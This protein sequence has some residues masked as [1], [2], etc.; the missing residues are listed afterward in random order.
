MDISQDLQQARN[1]ISDWVLVTASAMSIPACITSLMR[2]RVIGWYWEMNLHA[3]ATIG[4]LCMVVFRHHIS[5]AIRTGFLVG[6]GFV[7]GIAGIFQFGM[8]SSSMPLLLITPPMAGILFGYRVGIALSVLAVV[9]VSGS[10]YG[11]INQKLA[12][13]FDLAA[14]FTLA[15]SWINF[16]LTMSL[17]LAVSVAANIM[18]EKQFLQ[19]LERAHQK[20]REL[21]LM[22]DER[23]VA[24]LKARTEAERLARTDELTGLPNRRAFMEK[25]RLMDAQARRNETPYCILMMDVDHFKKIN[26][27]WGHNGGD[28]VLRNLG[29]VL[30]GRFRTTDACGRVGGEEFAIMLPDTTS[31]EAFDLADQIRI[32][33]AQSGLHTPEAQIRY[34]C[35]IGVAQ[36]DDSQSS[37]EKVIGNADTALYAAKNGGRNQVL[38]FHLAMVS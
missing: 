31:Q 36:W 5:F 28:A 37:L 14:Y 22:V 16:L 26:D 1:Q 12:T 6:V 17:A 4:L 11:V 25:A 8:L 7:L 33:V 19:A 18:L 30:K 15:P 20:R 3:L 2:S 34:T 27:T 35:S 24:L 32:V 13:G 38:C 10:A 23:T 9:L 29:Q 21:S